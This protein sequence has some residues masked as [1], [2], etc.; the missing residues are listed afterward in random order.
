MK[1]VHHERSVRVPSNRTKVAGAGIRADTSHTH[2]P[3]SIYYSF[4]IENG[5]TA[6]DGPA[7]DGQLTISAHSM[8]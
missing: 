7:I 8:S 4:N 2:W 6:D 5:R 1:A 3:T